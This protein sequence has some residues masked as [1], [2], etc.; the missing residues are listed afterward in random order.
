MVHKSTIQQQGGG[1]A[2]SSV[3]GRTGAV[4]AQSSDYSSFYLQRSLNLS[5][6]N[7]VTAA[8]YNLFN[9]YVNTQYALLYVGATGTGNLTIYDDPLILTDQNGNL[10]TNSYLIGSPGYS[11]SGVNFAQFTGN[12]NNFYQVSIQNTNAGSS[13]SSDFIVTANNGNDTTH[14]A[15]FGMN[16]SGG[17]V[18]PFTAA[19]AAYLYST[20]NE[21]DIGALGASGVINFYTTGTTSAPVKAGSF[22]ATQQFS[23]VGGIVSTKVIK[24]TTTAANATSITPNTD[25]ADITYQANTQAVG[26]LTINADAGVGQTNGRSWLLKIK[27]TNVQT[28]SWT[29]GYVGGTTALPTTTTGGGKIDNYSFIYDTVNSKFQFTGQALGF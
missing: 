15:D 22:S 26:T 2:V 11:T 4:T 7:S 6:L 16:S 29:S 23:A 25:T 10:T 19:N 14:Y 20:D 21:V 5:D 28:F 17:G 13:A 12:A 9:P 18:T 1:G 3:F 27:S 24:T 8:Q